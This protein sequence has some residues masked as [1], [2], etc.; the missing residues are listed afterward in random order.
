MKVFVTGGTGFVGNHLVN[1]LLDD[2]YQVRCLVRPGSEKKLARRHDVDIWPGDIFDGQ[3]R[4]ADG[5]EDCQAV[6]HL[7]GI[8]RE[9]P[10][11]G[12]TFERLH[13][14]AAVQVVNAAQAAGIKRY[15]HMSSLGTRPNARSRYHQTKYKAEEYVRRSGLDFTIFQPSVIFGPRD[16]FVNLFREMILKSPFIP[17]VGDGSYALQPVDVRTVARAFTLSLKEEKTIGRVFQLSGRDRFTFNDIL[18]I[19]ARA[20]EKKIIKAH[21]PVGLIRI[22]AYFLEGLPGFPLARDQIVMLLEGN[23]GSETSFYE[24]FGIAPTPFE[25]GIKEYIRG[26]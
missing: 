12:I 16:N 5:M 18:D 23:I 2:G 8:I 14:Q 17:V 4:L 10:R 1:A 9:F 13:Y 19:I 24:E 25:A 15:I 6:I 22:M 26:G 11:K 7:I 3:D 21:I 20:L